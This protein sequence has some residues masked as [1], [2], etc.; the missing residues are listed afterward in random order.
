ML[1]CQGFNS[2][3]LGNAARSRAKPLRRCPIRRGGGPAAARSNARVPTARRHS[4]ARRPWLPFRHRGSWHATAALVSCD[5]RLTPCL[6]APD[7]CGCFRPFAPLLGRLQRWPRPSS[8]A[9]ACQHL[10]TATLGRAFVSWPRSSPFSPI[11]KVLCCSSLSSLTRYRLFMTP[12]LGSELIPPLE[13]N[14]ANQ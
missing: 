10:P 9:R 13:R 11:A 2:F 5:S 8:P 6:Q 14:L 7:A 4:T 12:L 3:F 1:F